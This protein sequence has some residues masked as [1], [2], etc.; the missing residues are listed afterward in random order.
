MCC[1]YL[2]QTANKKSIKKKNLLEKLSTVQTHTV[3]DTLYHCDTSRML[4]FTTV[5]FERVRNLK[6][7]SLHGAVCNATGNSI[8]LIVFSI[9]RQ[10][11]TTK[12]ENILFCQ[13]DALAFLANASYIR[14]DSRANITYE[15]KI[16][17]RRAAFLILYIIIKTRTSRAQYI[18]IIYARVIPEL[19]CVRNNQYISV[20]CG[21]HYYVIIVWSR[22]VTVSLV[23][24]I[25]KFRTR[26]IILL[27]HIHVLHV[28]LYTS[29]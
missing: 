9:A 4:S 29:A 16:Y 25:P 28:L 15:Y 14:G 23:G 6:Q 19:V 1:W 21:Y 18:N 11:L 3:G 27:N 5:I 20:N 26:G 12:I 13:R 7:M 8:V 10:R 17:Q 22:G 24:F 2:F